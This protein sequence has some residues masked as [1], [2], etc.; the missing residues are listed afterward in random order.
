MVSEFLTDVLHQDAP[1]A[2]GR[3]F[4]DTYLQ[5]WNKGIRYIPKVPALLH[6]LAGSHTIALVT[7]THSAELVRDHLWN[8]GVAHT[9]SAVVTSV[10]HGKRKPAASIFEQALKLTSG[11]SEHAIY[12]GDSFEADYVGAGNAG[13]RCLLID[14]QKAHDVPEEY[15]MDSVLDLSRMLLR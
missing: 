11:R 10:E 2:L 7:N 1:P 15:R 9:F 14:P 5:E 6:Q 8:M 4:R 13:V 3:N 12:V